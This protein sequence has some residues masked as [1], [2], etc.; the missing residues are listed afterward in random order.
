MAKADWIKIRNEYE[1]TNI[2]QRKLAEKHNVSYN[3]LKYRSK[4]E[5]WAK[6]KTE[7]HRKI[8]AK[9]QQKTVVKIVD[10]NAKILS[11]ADKLANKIEN[12]VE[13]LENYLVTNKTKTKTVELDPRLGKPIKEVVV[14]EEVKEIVAGIIDK[15]G[16]KMLTAAL[17]DIRDIQP[18]DDGGN[19]K[20]QLSELKG[21]IQAGPVK[22][23]DS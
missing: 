14:E 5:E 2:S 13:Q 4:R 9:S 19:T 7:I 3:T 23:N 22:R 6:S 17:K 15:Q 10:R 8:T 18:K 1:A 11:I 16:L 12:A 21:I 20:G